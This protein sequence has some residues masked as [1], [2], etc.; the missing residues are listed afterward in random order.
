MAVYFSTEDRNNKRGDV[1]IRLSWHCQDERFQTTIGLS[2]QNIISGNR[3]KGGIYDSK[4]MTPEEINIIL[5]RI[6]KFM[7]RCEAYALELGV[8]L[9]NGIMRGLF[10]DYKS[11]RFTCE[12]EV[13]ERWIKSTPSNGLYWHK[14]D[15]GFYKKLCEA[16]DSVDNKKW[17]VI[18]QEVFG[19]SRIFS[20]PKDD[21]EGYIE[22]KGELKKLFVEVS[23]NEA[24]SAFLMKDLGDYQLAELHKVSK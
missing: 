19:H 2:T 14:V 11:M 12:K 16:A 1:L 20:M 18:F 10:K 3:V 5:G 21:F 4:S 15:G 24:I 9:K 8:K 7:Y 6:E 17:Y 23:E 13:M 22:L